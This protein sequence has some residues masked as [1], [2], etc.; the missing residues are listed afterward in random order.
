MILAKIGHGLGL[1]HEKLFWTEILVGAFVADFPD[2]GQLPNLPLIEALYQSYSEN[3]ESVDASWRHFFEGI[4]FAKILYERGRKEEVD[5]SSL[6][7]L[8]LIQ[9]YRRYGHLLAHFN[10][11]EEGEKEIAWL[12]LQ[13]LGFAESELDQPFPTLGFCGKKEAT[14]R[15]ILAALG[16]IYCGRIGFEYMDLGNP[17]LELWMQKRIE[18]TLSIHPSIEEKHL[19]LEHLNK[20][21]VLETFIHTKYLGQKRFS[22]EGV[23]T[24]IPMLAEILSL[25]ADL[26]VEEWIFGMAHRGR[27]NV[28]ANILNKP[29]EMIFQEF[30]D[31]IPLSFEESGDVKYHKGFSADVKTAKGKAIHIHLAANSSCLESVDPVVLGQTHAR[32]Q[33]QNKKESIGSLL[34]H[35]DAA[36]AGQGVVYESLQFCRLPAYEVGGTLHIVI[37]NQIGYTTPPE[38]GRSTRYCTDIGKGF[39]APVFHVNAEDPEGCI[40]AARLALEIRLKFRSDVFIDLNGYRKYGHN[41]GDEPG[42]TQPLQYRNIRSRKPIR[43]LYSEELAQQGHLEQKMAEALEMQFK[44]T[45]NEALAKAKGGGKKGGKKEVPPH[46]EAIFESF[47]TKVELPLLQQVGRAILQI[48][49]G[50]HLNPKLEKLLEERR[51]MLEGKRGVDWGMG[52]S[53]AFATLLWQTIPVRLA[54]QDA[55]R[56]TFSQRHSFL[57]DQ[58]DGRSYCPLSHLKEEQARFD[59]INSPLSEF[60]ALAFE[61]GY[62]WGD[63]KSLVLWEA[64]YGD[65]V[66]GAEIP[67]DHYITAGEQK[68]GRF[69]SLSLLLPHG[70]EGGGPEHSSGRIERFLQLSA[71][72]NIQVV[73][74][75]TPAQYFHLLRRQALR[76]LKKPLIVFT[77]KGL[78]RLPA[79]VSPIS[80][81]AEKGFEEILDDPAPPKTLKRLFLC[82]GKIYYDLLATRDSFPDAAIIRLEQ[83]YPLHVARLQKLFAKYKA[84]SECCWVQEEPENMGAWEFLRPVFFEL[85]PASMPLRYVGRIRSAATATGSL[86]QHKKEQQS[87]LQALKGPHESRNQSPRRR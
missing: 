10:P 39:G 30:E 76:P 83:L 51:S 22:L 1:G 8:G 29:Y 86:N 33:S 27:L 37:N 36:L 41:E 66:I 45:L 17:E 46:K 44:T 61:L 26:G 60:A 5:R 49:Q 43:E 18:P 21:E 85:L 84:V 4:D 20:S 71:Q 35:G 14:L 32:Q 58:E 64:Q 87:I 19:I 68:W 77:P 15:E 9:S 23:E 11:L 24:L 67:I 54:G 47:S 38:E 81:F 79:F 73:Y 31:N 53:L 52:E 62:T 28:L 48:P 59:A 74:P 82:T 25:G 2:Y 34:I 40:F 55:S 42:F 78:L 75:T 13:Q 80:D 50:F 63:P 65:F 6:R 16:A 56:G 12:E 69:S 72:H 3:P 70:Y 7:I 57:F